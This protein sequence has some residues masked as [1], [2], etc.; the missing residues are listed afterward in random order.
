M[1]SKLPIPQPLLRKIILTPLL[2]IGCLIFGIAAHIGAEDRT[3]LMLSG[4]LFV[5]CIYKGVQS[6]RIA[7]SAQYEIVCGTC[8]RLSP[9]LFGKL[10]KVILMDDAGVEI[11]LRLPKQYRMMI[12]SRY[13]FYFH[14]TASQ[15]SVGNEYLDTLL[16]TDSF[17][18]YELAEE[19][20]RKSMSSKQ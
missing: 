9:Q 20:E 2:G 16:S 6:Y 3:L 13:R 1:K 4:V 7:S 11:T 15:H 17:L 10:R 18:G 14:K 19:G 12:G 8:V 5:F